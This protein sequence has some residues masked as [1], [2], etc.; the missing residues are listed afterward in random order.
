M[1]AVGRHADQVG[2]VAGADDGPRG[3]PEPWAPDEAD[4]AV[5]RHV[6]EDALGTLRPLARA[7]V[8]LRHVYG[9]EYAEI[10]Q[11]LGT[12]AGNVGSL[13]TRSHATLRARL[14]GDLMRPT[15]HVDP[16]RRVAR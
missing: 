5:E 14:A 4:R 9:Y 7:A 13:L 6:L 1:P 12:S 10:G 2:E 11:M 16:A 8:V 3:R 15:V